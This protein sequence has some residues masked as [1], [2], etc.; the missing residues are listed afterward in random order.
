MKLRQGD[1][2]RLHGSIVPIYDKMGRGWYRG[3]GVY[4]GKLTRIWKNGTVAVEIVNE[5]GNLCVIYPAL[6]DLAP[7]EAPEDC[8]WH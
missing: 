1:A 7:I 8:T 4:E 5:R 3:Q 2:V 6:E